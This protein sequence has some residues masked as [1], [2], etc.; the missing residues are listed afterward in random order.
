MSQNS[1]QQNHLPKKIGNTMIVIAWII[2]LGIL[3]LLFS[4]YLNHQDNPNYNVVSQTS[5][6][7]SEVTLEQN[8]GG[9]YVATAR[10][11]NNPVNVIID[12]GATD[13]SVP[14]EIADRIGL[15]RGPVME[16]ITANGTIPVYITII[17][18]I[19][20]GQ[21][22]LSNVRA[23]INP[24]MDNDFVL[25]GMS[26]LKQLEFTQSNGRLIIRQHNN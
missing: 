25:L 1:D 13:V 18:S 15:Q 11:N 24:Y 4:K 8:R 9:H 23:S 6:G 12:T 7:I 10:F 19:E 20:L 2:F 26:F 21:I 17:D 14:A 22:V 5:A 3:T 16:V